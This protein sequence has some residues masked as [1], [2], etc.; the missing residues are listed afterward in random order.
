MIWGA[1]IRSQKPEHNEGGE[2]FVGNTFPVLSAPSIALK[3]KKSSCD[4]FNMKRP[5]VVL[6]CCWIGVSELTILLWRSRNVRCLL[7]KASFSPNRD[8]S[9]ERVTGISCGWFYLVPSCYWQSFSFFDWPTCVKEQRRNT[10]EGS[11][12]RFTTVDKAEVVSERPTMMLERLL[13]QFYAVASMALQRLKGLF[14]SE[15]M[16]LSHVCYV[17]SFYHIKWL[18]PHFISSLLMMLVKK[19]DT[20]NYKQ[21]ITLCLLF[22]T[23]VCCAVLCWTWR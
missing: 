5:P 14:P 13:L 3:C 1:T 20:S 23:C 12:D 7:L 17:T 2:G 15:N 22:V 9:S 8:Y 4:S 10:C 16:S 11:L 19:K 6:R 18:N 21:K